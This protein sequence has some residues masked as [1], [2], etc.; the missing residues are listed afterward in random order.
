MHRRKVQE[1]PSDV[2]VGTG[3]GGKGS[4][5]RRGLPERYSKTERRRRD[6][7]REGVY[8]DQRRAKCIIGA[9]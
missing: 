3:T 2:V 7:R 1:G 4:E 8:S 6:S 9:Q 5:V